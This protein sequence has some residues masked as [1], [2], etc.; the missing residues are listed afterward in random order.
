MHVEL[1]MQAMIALL[2]ALQRNDDERA[3]REHD[4]IG[5]FLDARKRQR[6]LQKDRGR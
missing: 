3:R 2:S 6:E 1:I 4:R 5:I